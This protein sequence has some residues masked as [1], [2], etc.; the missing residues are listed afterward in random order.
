[1]TEFVFPP[2]ALSSVAV[3]GSAQRYPVHRIYCVGLN[4]AAHIKEIG[5]DPRR[6]RCSS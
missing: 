1:M 5:A 4:Y 3:A 2:P 6:P